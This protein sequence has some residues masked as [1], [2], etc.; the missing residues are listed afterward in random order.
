MI[1]WQLQPAPSS[2]VGAIVLDSA[3]F[4]AMLAGIRPAAVRAKFAEVGLTSASVQLHDMKG[5]AVVLPTREVP[6]V[7]FCGWMPVLSE[8]AKLLGIELG[9]SDD[10]FL[11]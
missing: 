8:R 11:P 2:R 9:S 5:D 6:D 7:V 1:L 10:D 4:E 3:L